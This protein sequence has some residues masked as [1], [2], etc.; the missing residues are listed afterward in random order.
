AHGGVGAVA[1]PHTLQ[2]SGHAEAAVG[3]RGA[4]GGPAR[5]RSMSVTRTSLT[6]MIASFSIAGCAKTPIVASAAVPAPSAA[7]R[8]P[9]PAL[10]A[11]SARVPASRAE[12]RTPAA[13]SRLATVA[14]RP[15]L[16]EF[17]S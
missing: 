7:L 15:P 6:L 5:R 8:A 17:R 9:S 4:R 1:L 2:R 13:G 3:S 14:E 16:S 12:A 11:P 10:P